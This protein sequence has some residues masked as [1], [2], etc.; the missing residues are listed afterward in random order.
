M[1]PVLPLGALADAFAGLSTEATGKRKVDGSL[2]ATR[3]GSTA[4]EA[5]ANE[6]FR[7]TMLLVREFRMEWPNMS[8]LTSDDVESIRWLLD[9][10]L[11]TATQTGHTGDIYD[12]N[13]TCWAIWL[14]QNQHALKAGGWKV[15]SD[16]AQ[17]VLRFESL[18]Y[19]LG[20]QHSRGGNKNLYDPATKKLLKRYKLPFKKMTVPPA[21]ENLFK[22]VKGARRLSNWIYNCQAQMDEHDRPTSMGLAPGIIAQ[23]PPERVA[24]PPLAAAAAAKRQAAWARV[25][26]A[27]RRRGGSNEAARPMRTAQEDSEDAELT[28]DVV[29]AVV[30]E[31]Q[32]APPPD[33]TESDEE[34]ERSI[35][36]MLE[37]QQGGGEQQRGMSLE[38][39]EELLMGE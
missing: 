21:S 3:L 38:Q 5:W 26:A 34:L 36:E 23:V 27:R 18:Y 16:A 1:L 29:R 6:R 28:R 9:C 14:V 32:H 4:T 24:A 11:F 22:Y 25:A 13:P 2:A 17:R 30:H 39:I 19:W 10:A 33:A 12:T 8:L 35:E 20:Q 37:E 15:E 31:S 7:Q